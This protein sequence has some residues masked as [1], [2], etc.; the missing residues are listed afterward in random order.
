ME[1]RRVGRSGGALAPPT[2]ASFGVVIDQQLMCLRMG[3]PLPRSQTRFL[4]FPYMHLPKIGVSGTGFIA[5][6]LVHLLERSPDFLISKVLTRRPLDS[7]DSV[8]RTYLTHSIEEMVDASDIVFECSG[9]AIHAT[10]V[11]LQAT[12]SGKRVVTINSEFHVTTGSYF[13]QRGDYVTE[14]DGDQPG[15]LARLKLEIEGMGFEPQAYVNLKGFLNPNPTYRDMAFWSEKQELALDQVVSFTDGTKLQI[16]Q[17]LVA[18][19]LGATIACE[20][21]IGSTVDSLS[22]LDYLVDAS[23][24]VDMPVSDYTLCKGAPPGVLIVA[25]NPE[26]DRRPGYLPFSR[27]MTTEGSGFV[28]LRPFHL[29]HLEALNT[30]RKVVQGEPELLTNSAA[31]RIGVGAVAKNPMKAGAVIKKGAGGFD[32]RGQ[33]VHMAD[34]PDAVPICLLKDTVLVRDVEPGEVVRF[35]HV[36][37][38][39]TAALRLYRK[40]RRSVKESRQVLSNHFCCFGLADFFSATPMQFLSLI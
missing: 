24:R 9:D 8:D 15:C 39:D 22:D 11:V 1:H 27:L 12:E 35:E 2:T 3:F 13:A 33:A 18:N 4:I 28:L 21:M 19:G 36:A 38:A 31:P 32:V 20:G 10:D 17:A 16:E 40:I 34:H 25:K 37:L 14:A 30:I 26:A 29:C 6:G 5:T 7:V 23:N